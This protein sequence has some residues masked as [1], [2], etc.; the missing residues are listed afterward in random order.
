MTQRTQNVQRT[1]GAGGNPWPWVVVAT[2]GERTARQ[3]CATRE[4]AEREAEH[5]RAAGWTAT[6]EE[7]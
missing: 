2:N 1:Q 5:V 4:E 3:H 6:V 7:E